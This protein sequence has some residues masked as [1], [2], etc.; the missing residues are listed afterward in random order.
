MADTE[1][2]KTSTDDPIIAPTQDAVPPPPLPTIRSNPPPPPPSPLTD[3]LRAE[4]VRQVEFYFSD[5]NLP[6]DDFLLKQLNRSPEGWVPLHV[7]AS[8]HKMK[9]LSGNLSNLVAALHTST[10]LLLSD[11]NL[12]VRR[13]VALPIVDLDEVRSRSVV[14]WNLPEQKPTVEKVIEMFSVAG[15]VAMARIRK[16]EH[17]EPL[18]LGR[19]KEQISRS[20]R[21][22]YALIEYSSVEEA[23]KA[24]ELLSDEN[25][26]RSGLQVKSLQPN[27]RRQSTPAAAAAG[28]GSKNTKQKRG[29]KKVKETSTST[30][31]DALATLSSLQIS[32]KEEGRE[33]QAQPEQPQSLDV[34]N[35]E[36]PTQTIGTDTTTTTTTIT[37]TTTTGGRKESREARAQQQRKSRA[38]YAT[39]ASGT[40]VAATAAAS[41]SKK[42]VAQNSTTSGGGVTSEKTNEN[43]DTTGGVGSSSAA[44][45]QPRMPVGPE[46]GFSVGRGK[47]VGNGSSLVLAAAMGGNQ[48]SPSPS[49]VVAPGSQSGGDVV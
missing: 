41:G 6:T 8:F 2:P 5:A 34:D 43:G 38:H 9:K 25:S 35:A 45:Q 13:L 33:A 46:R 19:L 36:Q 29:E 16:P 14:A 22:C 31:S 11:D 17:P 49:A 48:S 30:S 47:P 32:A 39:W 12:K 4:I 15:T 21:D 26:W 18:L 23:A 24:V 44:V 37:T 3:E 42:I 40:A 27:N 10:E 20:V 1:A 28:G 7:I